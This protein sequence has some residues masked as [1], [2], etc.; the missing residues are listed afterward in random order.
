[1]AMPQP[2]NIIIRYQSP[3]T[4]KPRIA[5]IFNKYSNT[6]LFSYTEKKI[7]SIKIWRNFFFVIL[8]I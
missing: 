7:N 3:T 5:M 2:N 4:L 1:M 6:S 8:V